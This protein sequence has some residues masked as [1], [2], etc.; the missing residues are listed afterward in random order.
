MAGGGGHLVWHNL[1][2]QEAAGIAPRVISGVVVPLSCTVAEHAT[3]LND[4]GW[5]I[6]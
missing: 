5:S 3:V 6:M 4:F 2:K 1:Q